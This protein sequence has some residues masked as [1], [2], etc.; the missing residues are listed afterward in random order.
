MKTIRVKGQDWHVE[1][2]RK[3]GNKL[4]VTLKGG[5]EIVCGAKTAEAVSVAFGAA[6]EAP[7]GKKLFAKV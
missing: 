7:T 4:V 5:Q 3:A 2:I 1:A 6:K